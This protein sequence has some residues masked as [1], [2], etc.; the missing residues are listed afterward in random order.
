MQAEQKQ[1]LFK[2]VCYIYR[3]LTNANLEGNC[4]SFQLEKKKRVSH[5]L[6]VAIHVKLYKALGINTM[7]HHHELPCGRGPDVTGK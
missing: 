4:G 2:K 6:H 5:K 1:T 3:I 7:T